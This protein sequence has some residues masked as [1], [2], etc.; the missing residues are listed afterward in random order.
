MRKYEMKDFVSKHIQDKRL[1]RY[2]RAKCESY[3]RFIVPLFMSNDYILGLDEDDF[4]I[5]GY[6]IIRFRDLTE[7]DYKG[8]L[9]EEILKK[10]EQLERYPIP[11]LRLNCWQTIFE[12][13]YNIGKNI[14]IENESIN[15]EES[16]F[17]IGSILHVYK[18]SIHFR[19]FDADG[20]WQDDPLIIPYSKITTVTFGSRY[21]DLFSKYV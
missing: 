17:A 1:L 3:Y 11:S 5:D 10:E 13:L 8:D 14:I 2:K 15:E 21:V 6:R 12:D 9:Y 4:I 7:I 16:E 20:I 18:N 19:H